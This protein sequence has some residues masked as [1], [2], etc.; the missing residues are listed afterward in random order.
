M[1]WADMDEWTKEEI[2]GLR[3]V[4]GVSQE[5]FATMLGVTRVYVNY[6]EKGVKTPSKMLKLLLSY[7]ERDARASE[8]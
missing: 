7:V 4:L 8:K 6:L 1:I 2:K 3:A 5:A